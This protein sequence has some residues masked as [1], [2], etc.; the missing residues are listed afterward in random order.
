MLLGEDY[1]AMFLTYGREKCKDAF[2]IVYL[3]EHAFYVGTFKI[4][5]LGQMTTAV[6]HIHFTH[7]CNH[8]MNS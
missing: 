6:A 1:G 8:E 7:K 4:H 3:P 2:H 5:L